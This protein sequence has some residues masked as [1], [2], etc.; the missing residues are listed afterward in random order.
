MKIKFSLWLIISFLST[1][2]I[3][4]ELKSTQ[5]FERNSRSIVLIFTFDDTGEIISQG[6][7]VVL[8]HNMVATN[9]HV[10]SGSKLIGIGHHKNR[11]LGRVIASYPEDDLCVLIFDEPIGIP[12][13]LE[14]LKPLAGEK[15]Y[16]LGHPQGMDLT[17]SEGLISGFR[18]IRQG[19]LI[20]ISAAISP[21]S[22]GG[23]LF[24]SSGKLVGITTSSL[25]ESQ[26][27]NFAVPAEKL[28]KIIDAIANSNAVNFGIPIVGQA[29]SVPEFP[30]TE[31]RLAY[32]RWLSRQSLK[33]TKWLPEI[34]TREEFLQ[35]VWYE[36]NRAGLDP[37]LVLALI[38][39]LS[40]Y[41]KFNISKVGSRGYMQILPKWVKIIG[42]G[43]V[44]KLF[45]MQ[46]NLRFGCVL[47]RHYADLNK[48]IQNATLNDY[49][50][51]V[52]GINENKSTLNVI[53]NKILLTKAIFEK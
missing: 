45:H 24:N 41:Q 9:C 14:V 2:G 35:T 7:G 17:I 49:L 6:S 50:V 46:T 42:D 23:G 47:L 30:D 10:T 31:Q 20:Q 48:G 28:I 1:I 12:A 52:A 53:L 37:D 11:R 22:S 18:R 5:I 33:I 34:Q 51:E 15:V 25:R 27:I 43:D 16:A 44:G 21:G 8:S 19:Q 36:S 40:K 26:N 38:Q 29:P 13:Q 32:L 39:T 4:Q 3:A